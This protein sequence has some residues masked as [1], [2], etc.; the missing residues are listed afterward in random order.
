MK[1]AL[2]LLAICLFACALGQAV[3]G[4]WTGVL[5]VSGTKLRL[6]FRFEK[7]SEGYKGTLDSPD[8]GAVGLAFDSV[9]LEGTKLTAELKMAGARF[10]GQVQS[11]QITGVWIQ[12]GNSLPIVLERTEKPPTLVRPQEPKRPFPYIEEEVTYENKTASVRLAGTLTIPGKDGPYPAVLLITGSGP[13]NRDEELLG[14]KPFLVIADYLTRAGIAV[15]RVDDRGVGGS[16][17]NIANATS[18]D[19]A[20]DVASGIKYLQTRPEIDSKRIGL[21]GHSEGGLIAPMVAANGKDVA[22]IVLLAGPAVTGEQ[23]IYEQSARIAK[24]GGASQSVVDRQKAYTKN[25]FQIIRSEKDPRK[26]QSKVRVAWHEFYVRLSSEEKKQVGPEETAFKV[27]AAT[28]LTKWF[29]YF[30][31]YDP[32]PTLRKVSVPVLALFGSHDL[33]VPADQNVEPMRKALAAGKNRDF[34][35]LTLPGL[36]HLFQNSPT[37]S[38]SEYLQIE[39]TM[40]PSVLK[41]VTAWILNHTR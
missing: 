4:A 12:G 15:L 16:S 6:V 9:R 33:Q 40:D 30:L 7:T 17:G 2:P 35:I 10:E 8:Q 36:N 26:L 41:M 14:H 37:G 32:V 39:Q 29:R 20:S 38:P 22:F 11:N 1:A 28:M 19:F 25:V 3:E 24:A 13:Q 31:F 21:I 27:Q 18:I 34:T 5:D 23:I